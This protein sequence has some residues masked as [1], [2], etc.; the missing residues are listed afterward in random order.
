MY[1]G[2]LIFLLKKGDGTVHI[3]KF[4][5]NGTVGPKVE[6]YKWS[7]GWSTVEFFHAGGKE[8]LFL[9]KKTG[10]D[11]DGM[12]NVHVHKRNSNGSVGSL[13][14]HYKWSEGWT[15]ARSFGVWKN[16]EKPYSSK[17]NS[18]IFLYKKGNGIVHI[19]KCE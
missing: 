16:S 7:P 17:R 15:H 8:Y 6:A 4:K 11:S 12:Y 9:L 10:L 3:H 5:N 13:V 14:E 19:H 18:F 1:T 2:H